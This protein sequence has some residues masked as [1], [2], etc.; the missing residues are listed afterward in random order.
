MLDVENRDE[1]HVD[2]DPQ[3]RELASWSRE[4]ESGLENFT[5]FWLQTDSASFATTAKW[6][7][8]GHSCQL[9]SC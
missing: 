3:R 6:K 8:I 5:A 1:Q 2:G 4:A 9:G 7:N